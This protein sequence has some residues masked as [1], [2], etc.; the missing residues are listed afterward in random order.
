[1][2]EPGL[3]IVTVEREGQV[4]VTVNMGPQHP[5]T[6]GVFRMLLQVDGERITRV[7]P[8]IGYLHRGSEKLCE[9]GTYRQIIPLF[10]RLDYLAAFNNELVLMMAIE[11]LLGVQV[12]E[13]AEFV[14]VILCE[15]N[16]IASHFMFY[17]AYGID[18]GAM[19][20]FMFG[21]RERERIQQL[22]ETVSGARM[23]HNYF[24]P[25]G[26]NE[27]VPDD[28]VDNVQALLPVLRRGLDEAH[29]LLTNNEIFRARTEGIGV[30]TARQAIDWSLSGPM[31]RASGVAEDIRRSEPYS[32]YDRFE[33]EIPIGDQGDCL[34]RYL[35]RM[36]EIAQSIR[37]VEQAVAGLPDG[38]ILGQVPK[39]IRPAAGDC[40][41]RAENPRG[42]FGVYL[43]SNGE[44][45]PY[46]VKVRGPSFVNL[47]A[48]QDLL[49]G[50][51]IAD[52]VVILGSIDIVLGEVDR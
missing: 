43:V 34:D 22:F 52:A 19:T 5:S 46:R 42:E 18:A 15:L 47:S 51:Y 3:Q 29:A 20:P 1:M 26:L 30:I 27:D 41:V 44:R 32:I 33:F 7:E 10:D 2:I 21:F 39:V 25:G 13:R 9:V 16:R 31:L 8:F 36:E 50:T 45:R 40:Y 23:M 37:I 35:V 17:G 4:D 12:A 6:H 14:R 24:R 38:P 11:K 28:F 49:L 48:I